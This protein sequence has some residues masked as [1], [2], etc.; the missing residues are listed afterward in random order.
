[1]GWAIAHEAGP[2]G[3]PFGSRSIASSGPLRPAS[4]CLPRRASLHYRP[5]RQPNTVGYANV[6]AGACCQ[7]GSPGEDPPVPLY[8]YQC[9]GGHRYEK[10]EPFGSPAHQPCERCKKPAHRLLSAPSIV[11]KGSGWYATDSKRTLRSG[12]GEDRSSSRSDDDG[13]ADDGA[14]GD[15]SD[16]DAKPA[17]K[18]PAA[19]KPAAKPK[20]TKSSSADD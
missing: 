9:E 11:F 13:G 1:M 19:K 12:V 3:F 8:D 14:S 5:T 4:R 17:A 16:A 15:S 10:Q 20:A 18:Q 2:T 6:G 7:T